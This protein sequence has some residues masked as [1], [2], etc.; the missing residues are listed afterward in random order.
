MLSSWAGIRPLV[1][2]YESDRKAEAEEE[3][4][5]KLNSKSILA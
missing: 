4:L 2:E 3:R 5:N 1:R